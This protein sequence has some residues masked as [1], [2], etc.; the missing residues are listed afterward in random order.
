MFIPNYG[1]FYERRQFTEGF[2]SNVT[3]KLDKDEVVFGG[4]IIYS[5]DNYPKLK[6]AVEI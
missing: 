5:F 3:V 2:K 4:S 6:V 1:E